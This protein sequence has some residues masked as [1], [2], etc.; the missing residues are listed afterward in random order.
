M[1]MVAD[2]QMPSLVNSHFR[3]G[4]SASVC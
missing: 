3:K 1:F 4:A 2:K